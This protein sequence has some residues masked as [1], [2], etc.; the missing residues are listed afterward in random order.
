VCVFN[1]QHTIGVGGIGVG[2]IGVGGIGVGGLFL[3]YYNDYGM[4]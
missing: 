1:D 2:G 4:I 3:K